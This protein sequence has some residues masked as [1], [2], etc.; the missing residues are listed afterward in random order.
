MSKKHS[1]DQYGMLVE[2]SLYKPVPNME[3]LRKR[4]N[5]YNELPI[6]SSHPKFAEPLVNIAD[7]GI[8]GQAYYSRPNTATQTPVHGVSAPLY[9]RQSIAETLA[10]VNAALQNP[11]IKGFF[12]GDVEL[13]VE[14]ALRPVALQRRLHDELIPALIH[15]NNPKMSRSEVARRVKDIIALPS[16]DPAKPSPHATGGA[17]DIILRY[18]QT[19]NNYAE[20][21]DVPMGHFDGETSER[22]NPDYFEKTEPRS[23]ED[24]LAQRNRR[25]YYAIMTGAAFGIDTGFICNPTEWW[26]WGRGDQLSEKIRGGSSAYYSLAGSE[27]GL[28]A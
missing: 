20:G 25:A 14:D 5:G 19:S 12:G 26:H 2:E 24:R 16:T 22:I 11:V 15:K 13:Y 3:E 10:K 18:K 17:L 23:N 9:V 21:S 6:E 1:Q 8:A 4:K 28:R 27:T 7:Y